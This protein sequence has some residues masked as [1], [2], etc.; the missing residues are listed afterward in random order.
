MSTRLT[1]A[2]IEIEQHVAAAGWDQPPR[3][4]ALVETTDLVRSEPALAEQLGALAEG[5]AAA[6]HLTSV[7]QEDLPEAASV[8]ELLA[9]IAWPEQVTGAALVLERLMLPPEAEAQLPEEEAAAVTWVA[10]HPE[11]QEVRLAV[12]VLRDG[13][14]ECAVRMRAHDS[15]NAVLSGP[16]LVPGLVDALAS[17][18]VD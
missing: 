7:E 6:D 10:E 4:Y 1:R 13:S 5:P 14:R 11:R 3:L 8:E 17:T 16:N 2:V 12:A 15:D 9:G 18:L